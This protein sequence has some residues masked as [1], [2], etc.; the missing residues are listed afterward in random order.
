M[1]VKELIEKLKQEELRAEKDK[2]QDELIEEK[3]FNV[4]LRKVQ[5]EHYISKDKIR[6]KIKEL[7]DNFIELLKD[8]SESE[9]AE[10]NHEYVEKR[11]LLENLL[12][13]E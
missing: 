12:E 10:L 9:K 11:S 5:D 3:Q 13:G 8:K 6:D 1:K 4:K 2:L 7:D